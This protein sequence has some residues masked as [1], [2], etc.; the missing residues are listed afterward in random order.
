M[1]DRVSEAYKTLGLAPGASDAELRAAHRRLVQLHHP[2]HNGG[3]QESEQRFEAVQEAY[4]EVL[5]ARRAAPSAE[6][7]QPPP[8]QAPPRQAPPRQAPPR[9]AQGPQPHVDLRI[10]ELER[11]LREAQA[12]RERAQRAA[13][14][15]A[16]A[17][18]PDRPRRPT[19]EE[20]GYVTTDDSLSKI[21][22]DA[23]DELS[24]RLSDARDSPVGKR[25]SDLL[26]ELDPRKH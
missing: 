17:N 8:R 25:L 14:Q 21:F 5:A 3:S 6:P 18:R 9:P 26:D 11:E 19:D 12:A 15:A 23:R 7:R 1:N 22:A 16:A 2:D 24:A 4:A 20:L 13:R 10:E